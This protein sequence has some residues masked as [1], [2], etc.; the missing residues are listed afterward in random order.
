MQHL[1]K[2]ASLKVI[3]FSYLYKLLVQNLLSMT[4]ISLTENSEFLVSI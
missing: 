2:N 1:K 3:I 4:D